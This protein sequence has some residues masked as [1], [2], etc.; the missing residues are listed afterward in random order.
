MSSLKLELT[1]RNIE[2]L[3]VSAEEGRICIYDTK[4]IGLHIRASYK[5]KIFYLFYRNQEKQQRKIRLGKFPN[6]MINDA[7]KKAEKILSD[8]FHGVDYYEVRKQK[9]IESDKKKE[10]SKKVKEVWQ[11]YYENYCVPHTK[12]YKETLRV[13]I[14]DISPFIGNKPIKEVSISDL[15]KIHTAKK[16][17]P[18]QANICITSMSG[19][20]NW[21]E[22]NGYRDLNSNPSRLVTKFK[23]Q[24]RNRF[25]TEEELIKIGNS[26]SYLENSEN[27][28]SKVI[29]KIIKMLIYTGCRLSEITKL[30]WTELD[31]NAGFLRLEDSK[32]GKKTVPLG[33]VAVDLLKDMPKAS[34][35]KEY[36]FANPKTQKPFV[37][38][39]RPWKAVLKEAKITEST[40]IHDLRHTFASI[41]AA[42]KVATKD[43]S[44]VLGHASV[45]TTEI[46]THIQDR[47]AR[48]T[49]N[50]ISSVIADLMEEKRTTLVQ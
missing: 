38:I 50:R 49:A 27:N 17:S 11:E 37:D 41:G 1:N 2:R 44:K 43:I 29:F 3:S 16:D 22:K 34:Y 23:S 35:N 40:H 5:N 8:A 31:L 36:V 30:K 7:R 45:K 32:T 13:F 25:L 24:K 46:Y 19:F 6:I 12:S 39:T 47:N 28:Y 14:K 9:I 18:R 48:T 21:C 20:L 15:N 10:K 42:N 4:T 33:N 26:I